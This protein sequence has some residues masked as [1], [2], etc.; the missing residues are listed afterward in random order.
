MREMI[1]KAVYSEPGAFLTQLNKAE[2][3]GQATLTYKCKSRILP[4][5]IYDTNVLPDQ[6]I[7]VLK[8]QLSPLGTVCL[9]NNFHTS[10]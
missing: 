10:E 4:K 8:M 1:S 5:F 6:S 3:P 9:A 7:S 2:R